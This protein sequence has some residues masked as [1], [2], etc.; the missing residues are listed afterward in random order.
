LVNR[1]KLKT[2]FAEEALYELINNFGFHRQSS[3]EIKTSI[4]SAFQD[5]I[6][7]AL[8]EM[9]DSLEDKKRL[10]IEASHHIQQAS[11]LLHG[12]PHPAGKMSYRLDSM[13]DTLNKLVEGSANFAEERATR[14]M[15]KNLIRRLRDIWQT[16]TSTPFYAGVDSYGHNPR[17]FLLSCMNAAESQYPEIRW[18]KEVDDKIADQLIKGIKRK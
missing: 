9:G 12:M 3:L 8:S 2:L 15:E 16:N 5:Y 11:K 7:S 17:E 6:L 4:E 18:F 10:Y 1:F 13:N 14:F